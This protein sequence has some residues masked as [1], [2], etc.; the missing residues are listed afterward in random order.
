[1]KRVLFAVASCAAMFALHAEA[2][3]VSVSISVGDPNFFGHIEIGSLPPPPL[4]Y[5][6]PMVIV[7][8]PRGVVVEPI[9]LRVPPGHAKNWRKYCRR[10][11]ACG[12]PVYFVKDEWY[13]NVYVPHYREHREE[14]RDER[15]EHRRDERRDFKDE[16]RHGHGR[17]NGNDNPGQGHGQGHGHGHDDD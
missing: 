9:Y 13:R 14:Y 7:K 17:G 5:A 1:M 16:D 6:E 11:D 3:D 12:R 15:H 8:P 2:A 4:I 10:Y